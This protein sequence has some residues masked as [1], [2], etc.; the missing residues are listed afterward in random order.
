MNKFKEEQNSIKL[1]WE[2]P[3]YTELIVSMGTNMMF[4]AGMDGGNVMSTM[5]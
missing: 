3:D 5:T 4:A 1:S 2:K